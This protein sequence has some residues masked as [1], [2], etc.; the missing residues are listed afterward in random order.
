MEKLLKELEVSQ[1]GVLIENTYTINL[2]TSNWYQYYFE[3]LEA[4]D[5]FEIDENSIH[6][7]FDENSV[8]FYN[9]AYEISLTANFSDNN[10][11]MKIEEK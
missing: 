1:K 2:Q 6:T 9:D 11:T 5:E 7:D 10:Y 3:K 4:N 8:V